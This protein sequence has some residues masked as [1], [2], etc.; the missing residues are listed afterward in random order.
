MVLKF[1]TQS[2]VFYTLA[3]ERAPHGAA[4][5]RGGAELCMHAILRS[6][7]RSIYVHIAT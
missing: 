2:S 7:R 4:R 1:N 3:S 6:K 5:L